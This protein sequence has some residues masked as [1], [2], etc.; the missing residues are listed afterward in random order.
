[1]MIKFKFDTMTTDRVKPAHIKRKPEIDYT[2]QHKATPT[3]E[4]TASKP[5]AKI[6]V[7]WTA[8]VGARTTTT[9]KPSRTGVDMKTNSHARSTVQTQENIPATYQRSDTTE[10][11]SLKP[12]ALYSAPHARTAI[13][14][15]ANGKN[16]GLQIY[17]STS[18]HLRNDMPA[19]VPQKTHADD[20]CDNNA[21]QNGKVTANKT[22]RQTRVGRQIHTPARFVQLVHAVIAPN[23]IYCRP[24]ARII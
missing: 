8:V 3:S 17:L 19:R 5:P 9:P 18:L 21:D 2:T 11:Q 14:S 20:R 23:D 1:M 13:L 12:P 7:P 15:R 6:S 10:A 16:E 22:F 4:P 24:S